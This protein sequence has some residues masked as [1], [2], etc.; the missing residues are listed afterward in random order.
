[1]SENLPIRG[2]NRIASPV[3]FGL[4]AQKP[5]HF[6]EMFEVL[7]ENRDSL[8]YAWNILDKG[9]CDGCSLG[10]RGLAD[11]VIEGVHLCTTRLKLMRLNTMPA[12]DPVDVADID[13]LRRM[14]NRQLQALGRIPYPLLHKKGDRGFRR[15]PWDEALALAGGA[16]RETPPERQAWFATS[17][18]ITN[19]TYY[20]FTKVARLS[21]TNNVDLCARLC[22]QATVSGLKGTIGVGAPTCSLKDLIGTDLLLLW[23]T[24]IANNQPVTMKYLAQAKAQ[25]TRIVVINPVREKGLESYWVPS[26]PMSAVFGTQLMDDF[27]PVAVGGDIALLNGVLKSLIEK[28]RIDHAFVNAHTTGFPALE[29]QLAATSWESLETDSGVDRAKIEWLAELYGRASTVVTIYSMGLTQ[30]TF[31]TENVE[32]IVNLHLARGMIG[33]PRTGILPI[34]GHSGVQGGGECGVA[35]GILPGGV[36]LNEENLTRFEGHWGRRLPRTPGLTTMGIV[37]RMG[38]DGIDFLYNLGGNLFAVLPDPVWVAASYAKVRFRVHQDIVFNTST[39][40]EGAET[41]LVLPAQ[42]RYEQRG[43]GTSTSTE[44]R[45]RFSPEI[46]GHPQVGECRPEYEIP[47]QVAIAAFPELATQLAYPDAGAIRR[48]MA[49]TMPIYAGIEALQKAGDWIQWGGEQLCR[50]GRF[51]GM[52]EEKARFTRLEP[53]RI[54]VPEGAFYLTTR[55]GKQFN[56]IV[57]KD[58]DP[59]QGGRARDDLLIAEADLARVGLRD[60]DRARLVSQTGR[61]D[62]TL[63]RADIRPGVVQAYWPECNVVIGRRIDPRSE[64]PDYNAVVR[65]ERV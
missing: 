26:M 9:V 39:V 30:H 24:D 16:L 40:L 28:G 20:A 52:P 1:M 44:R 49:L 62:V 19:E 61:F 36:P 60:G 64:E 35:P 12:F 43:G 15:I 7:W 46:P 41:I 56:S 2:T 33:R 23:G 34:R 11:D 18:G 53:V 57:I 37:E 63:R 5:H 59:L 31:G 47:C 54:A 51:V 8:R 13:R 14:D 42:T 50:E 17:R 48:E 29:A 21:G 45:V 55:R 10:P 6:L 27:V 32:A 65:I 25:G 38:E 4:G 22:H 58:H 3:P